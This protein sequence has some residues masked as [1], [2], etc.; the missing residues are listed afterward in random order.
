MDDRAGDDVAPVGLDYAA[1]RAA[2]RRARVRQID[3]DHVLPLDA[4]IA[5]VDSLQAGRAFW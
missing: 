1:V 3:P 2:C 5:L 4:A